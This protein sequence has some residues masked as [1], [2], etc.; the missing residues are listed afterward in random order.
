[1]KKPDNVLAFRERRSLNT[2]DSSVFHFVADWVNAMRKTETEALY[3]A[4][5]RMQSAVTIRAEQTFLNNTPSWA[6][7]GK[8]LEVAYGL[9]EVVGSIAPIYPEKKFDQI[10]F[11]IDTYRT[12]SGNHRREYGINNLSSDAFPIADNKYDAVVLRWI[13]QYCADH[14]Q[15]LQRMR[16]AVK[17]G[18]SLFIIE[19]VDAEA[20]FS[21]PIAALD[22]FYQK[23]NFFQKASGGNRDV[24]QAI[25]EEKELPGFEV[26]SS[27]K[28]PISV[29]SPEDK[30]AMT[31]MYTL[32]AEFVERSYKIKV[33]VEKLAHDFLSWQFNQGAW[34]QVTMQY[35]EIKRVL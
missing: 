18:G 15:L 35:L 28:D 9:E 24:I 30:D 34:G 6:S 31:R 25:L 5:Q 26:V 16:R 12:K 13:A 14:Q 21:P 22:D 17:L 8:V 7:A 4:M 29:F 23:L 19:P 33:S 2:L 32:I 1:M 3:L 11:F 20:K 10:P 27:K